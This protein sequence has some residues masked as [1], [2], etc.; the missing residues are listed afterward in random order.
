MSE[1]VSKDLKKEL[2]K[3]LEEEGG[4]CPICKKKYG[5]IV[6][7]QDEVEFFK[8]ILD[9]DL[10]DLYWELGVLVMEYGIDLEGESDDAED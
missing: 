2:R 8:H 3:W 4:V 1:E 9:H 10:D 5:K 6:K 7:F